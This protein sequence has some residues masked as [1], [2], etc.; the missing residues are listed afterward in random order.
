MEN[1]EHLKDIGK[2]IAK[3]RKSHKTTQ[4][5]LAEM[6]D[7]SPKHISHSER[8][9]SGLSLKNLIDFCE[10]FNV[11][12]DYVVLGEEKSAVSKLPKEIVNILNTGNEKDLKRLNKYLETYLEIIND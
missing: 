7:V 3:V 5:Q 8:G 12:L 2:R 4:A 6:L 11:S 1:N 10:H 9:T